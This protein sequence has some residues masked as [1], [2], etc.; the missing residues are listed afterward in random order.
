M[1]NRYEQGRVE[2]RAPKDGMYAKSDYAQ[3]ATLHG[4]QQRDA[5]PA[6][7]YSDATIGQTTLSVGG[8]SMNILTLRNLTIGAVIIALVFVALRLLSHGLI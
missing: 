6:A 4:I 7:R 2:A 5:A 3:L 8:G 1:T